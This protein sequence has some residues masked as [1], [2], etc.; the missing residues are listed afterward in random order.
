MKFFV[1]GIYRYP[2]LKYSP[3]IGDHRKF[4]LIKS[5]LMKLYRNY[6]FMVE[7]EWI[8]PLPPKWRS[9]KYSRNSILSLPSLFSLNLSIV[10]C[11]KIRI[12]IS[13]QYISNYKL[14]ITSDSTRIN[15]FRNSPEP[16]PLLHRS[17]THKKANNTSQTLAWH[18]A[19]R[20]TA[21]QHIIMNLG[22]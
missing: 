19:T 4:C 18:E 17:D 16:E 8:S 9:S 13:A 22:R 10:T 12:N 11:T 15:E 21:H 5:K 20:R 7:M 1:G 2:N 14:M 6:F 3:L